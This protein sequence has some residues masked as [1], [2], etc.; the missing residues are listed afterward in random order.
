MRILILN[1]N[2]FRA[3]YNN[4]IEMI[5]QSY[6]KLQVD[7]FVLNKVNAKQTINN[8]KMRCKLRELQ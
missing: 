4:K 5:V 3:T 2:G 6:K 7:V 1:L 8:K